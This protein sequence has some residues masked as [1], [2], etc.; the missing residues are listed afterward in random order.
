[1]AIRTEDGFSRLI[2]LIYA[3]AIDAELWP[4]LLRQLSSG[5][6]CHFGGRVIS[7]TDR[8]FFEGM[9]VGVSRDAHQD[10]LRRFHRSSPFRVGV[11][12]EHGAVRDGRSLVPRAR[13]EQTEMYQSFFRPHEIGEALQLTLWLNEH[14]QQTVTL[15]R[16]WSRGGFDAEDLRWI[17]SLMPHLCRAAEVSWRLRRAALRSGIFQEAL[18]AVSHAM[19]LLDRSGHVVF[20]NTAATELI[21]VNDT[22]TVHAGRL[23]STTDVGAAQLAALLAAASRPDGVAGTARLARPSG[24][25]ALAL[26][27]MPLRKPA[28]DLMLMP[29]EPAVLLCLSDLANPVRPS[30]HVFMRLF[31]LTRAQAELAADL[32]A[33]KDLRAIADESGRSVNTMRVHLARL[34]AKTE[35][36][37]QSEL[38]RVLSH[39]PS[40]RMNAPAM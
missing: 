13:L 29:R 38:I 22:L 26:I 14:G 21:R 4:D 15:A 3:A 37:R 5:V 20:A 17:R 36:S 35:T 6:D 40:G 32:L 34:M 16:A 24:G 31:R 28:L 10:F 39:L 33:G 18:E 30:M 25:P 2:D 19:L 27:A 7:T 8:R 9:A 12:M 1:M 11:P 23:G